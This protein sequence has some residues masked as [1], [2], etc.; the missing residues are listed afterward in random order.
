MQSKGT[1]SNLDPRV[2]EY[3][4][5]HEQNE[6]TLWERREYFAKL[7]KMDNI[8]HMK[9]SNQ[10]NAHFITKYCFQTRRLISNYELN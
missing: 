6:L 8:Q 4:V 7:N 10:S 5:N 9:I 2:K 1:M 3:R